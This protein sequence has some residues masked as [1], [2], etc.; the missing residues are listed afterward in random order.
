[1]PTDIKHLISRLQRR[2]VS[3][4]DFRDNWTDL[5]FSEKFL[6]PIFEQID[7]D[8]VRAHIFP[9]P[10]EVVA[11][12]NEDNAYD[13]IFRI[14]VLGPDYLFIKS[15]KEASTLVYNRLFR[16]YVVP[17]RYAR[18]NTFTDNRAIMVAPPP[19]T[20][21]LRN[22]VSVK[23]PWSNTKQLVSLCKARNEFKRGAKIKKQKERLRK[24]G[25]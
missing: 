14:A 21:W 23:Q 20:N 10:G 8:L 19:G 17:L 5:L 18:K 6:T 3:Q 16:E 12:I 9:R 13:I 1:M 25:Y 11:P 22:P 15:P 2:Y 24:M 4:D 7:Q